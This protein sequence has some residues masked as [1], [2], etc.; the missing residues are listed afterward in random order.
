MTHEYMDY[1]DTC[2]EQ[3]TYGLSINI[4]NPTILMH[5]FFLDD[6][7]KS[8]ESVPSWVPKR[9]RFPY[10][11]FYELDFIHLIYASNIRQSC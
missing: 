8:S 3:E 9:Y 4:K 5:P 1:S 6:R 7:N 11:F 2:S 10:R